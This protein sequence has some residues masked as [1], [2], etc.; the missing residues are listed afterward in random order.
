[1]DDGIRLDIT[2]YIPTGSPPSGGFPAVIFVHG[3]SGN[4]TKMD[5]NAQEYA[6]S[7]YVTVTY[8]VRGQGNSEGLTTVFSTREQK[9]LERIIDWLADR[10]I[11]NAEKIGV[12]GASQGGYHSWFAGVNQMKVRAVAPEN[13]TP[14]RVDAIARY[15]CYSMKVT[16]EM[17]Y[18]QNLRLDTLLYPLK[19]WLLADQYDSVRAVVNRGRYFDSTDVAASSAIYYMAGSWHDHVFPH[20]K[21]TGAFRVA[22]EGS[23][24]Y[25]G[26]IGHQSGYSFTEAKFREDIKHKFFAEILKGEDQD[27]DSFGPVMISL[28]PSW[29]H[30]NFKTWPPDAQKYQSY[31]MNSNGSLSQTFSESKTSS[32][33]IQHQLKNPSYTWEEAIRGEFRSVSKHFLQ[34]R[35]SWLS[36]PLTDT[37]KILGI[38]TAQIYAK[39]SAHRFQINLQLYAEPPSGPPVYLSQISLGQRQNPD[40]TVWHFMQ[41]ELVIIGWEIPPGYSLRVDWTSINQ[42][43]TDT[44]LWTLPYWNADGKLSIGLDAEHPASINIPVLMKQETS[45][46]LENS[47]NDINLS[48]EMKLFQNFPNPFNPKT[49]ISFSMNKK[50]Y[51]SLKIYDI[52]G[53]EKA[54]LIDKTM[55][56]GPHKIEFYSDECSSGIYFICLNTP[57]FSQTRKMILIK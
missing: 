49:T 10:P 44:S 21:V 42:T 53:C 15:G 9:D 18:R 38:P 52:M 40:S 33:Y 22:P 26:V 2:R 51:V 55:K 23:I 29:K 1:M 41:G 43:L 32:W 19:K 35:R 13:S 8:S 39:G 48:L 11:V 5:R 4:K 46:D 20:N 50:E 36:E 25:L 12:S 30:Y 6:D 31:Y 14:V 27:L 16:A 3:L 17:N 34:E 24:M 7:G 56:P 37:L 28:G 54:V 45:I 47:L 57:S